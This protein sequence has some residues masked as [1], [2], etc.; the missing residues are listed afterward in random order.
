MQI[1]EEG[2]QFLSAAAIDAGRRFIEKEDL[3]LLEKSR[4]NEDAL[5]L[6][7]GEHPKLL[8]GQISGVQPLQHRLNVFALI[9]RQ[10]TAPNGRP[11]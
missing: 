10:P 2:L 9:L 6:P 5:K 4:R 7:T 11:P 8:P 1:L 3:G